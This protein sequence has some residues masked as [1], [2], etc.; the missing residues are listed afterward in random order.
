MPQGGVGQHNWRAAL[1]ARVSTSD[2]N[3]DLQ[4]REMRE[5]AARRGWSLKEYVDRGISGVETRRPHL[6][7]L[8]ED[9]QAHRLDV[10]LVWKFDR[11]FRSVQHM[12]EFLAR[13]QKL[14]VE[15]V[16]LTEQIDTSSP[17][18][19]LI[20]HVLAAIAEFEREMIRE[21]VVAGL[22]AAE[23][24]GQI[25]GHPQKPIDEARIREDYRLLK[26]YRRVAEIHHVSKATI[27]RVCQGR[28]SERRSAERA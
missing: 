4:L 5:Y 10:V 24:R 12:V 27:I 8:T 3:V 23:A 1:Y 9:L 17:S 14:Q 25:L 6:A 21:R 16:S 28:R 22:R 7:Q 20:F 19:K 26:S 11:L 18:G 2:Q 13:L 15:F